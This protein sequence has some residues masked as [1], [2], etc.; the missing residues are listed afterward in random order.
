MIPSSVPLSEGVAKLSTMKMEGS[1]GQGMG[2]RVKVQSS[3]D[4]DHP[5]HTP[6]LGFPM[7]RSSK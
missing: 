2:I 4:Q 5:R 3:M 7:C 6:V 1:L